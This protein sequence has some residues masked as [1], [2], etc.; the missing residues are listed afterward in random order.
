M[1]LS[2][3]ARQLR[4]IETLAGSSYVSAEA[5]CDKLG[6]TRRTLFRYLDLFRTNGFLVE[7]NRDG[8]R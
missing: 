5:I 6:I 4:L 3:F 7:R 8:Y 2:I 1:Q